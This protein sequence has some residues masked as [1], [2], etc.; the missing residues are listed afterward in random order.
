M[1]AAAFFDLDRTLLVG[2]SGPVISDELRR[3]GLIPERHVPGEGLMFD[4]F[5][6]VGETLPGMLLTR[7]AARAASGWPQVAVQRVGEAIV[8]PLLDAMAPFA[9][10]LIDEHREAGRPVVLATTTPYDAVKPF[11]DALGL[12]DVIATRYGLR[13]DGAYDGTIDGEFVW[14][15]G[16]LNA[17]RSWCR[18]HGIEVRDSWAYSD[19]FYDLPLLSAAGHATAVNPDVRLAIVAAARRWPV[20]HLDVPPGVP[21]L[22]GVEPQ[23]VLL[24]LVRSELIPY[25]RFDVDGVH[26][27]PA[28]GPAII[29][30][31]HRSY[32]DPMAVALTIAKRGRPVRFLGKKEVFDAPV[33][34]QVARA[35]GGIRVDRATGSDEPLRAAAQALEAGEMV[36]LMPQGTIPRGRSFFDPKLTGRW[37]ASRLA[38][39][40]G[41]PVIPMGLW[42][43]EKVW[44]RAARLPNVLNLTDPPVIRIRVGGPA[45]LSLDDPEADTAAI[46]AAIVKLLP[47]EARKRRRPT[48]EELRLTFP[49]GY[50]GDPD[51]E[52]SRRPGT[53]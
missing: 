52:D 24:P 12:D 31:N 39:M 26:N 51:A 45:A 14:G 28:I 30:A 10:L 4:V 1:P 21:K 18:A 44:P 50:S 37:G 34:G 36:A 38:A 8:E 13:S 49:P 48:E 23:Q 20:L 6:L 16:K 2:A 11:A 27:I 42:R 7:Q 33:V 25:A 40:T 35:M 17:V 32:F 22:A 3:E 47:P 15:R 9:R 43:T 41:A 5:N 53:D 29:C 19:S 46:M